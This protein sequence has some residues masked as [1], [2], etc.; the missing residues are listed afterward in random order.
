MKNHRDELDKSEAA[1]LRYYKA[2]KYVSECTLE[3]AEKPSGYYSIKLKVKLTGGVEKLKTMGE[4]TER[5]EFLEQVTAH[6]V[7]G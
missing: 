7:D 5:L 4:C 2:H 1:M 6:L 3:G